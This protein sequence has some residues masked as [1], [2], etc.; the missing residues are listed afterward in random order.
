MHLAFYRKDWRGEASR[1]QGS[2]TQ[3]LMLLEQVYHF[4]FFFFLVEEENYNYA[5]L[6]REMKRL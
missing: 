3:W 2:S 1:K 5:I 4:P 6:C